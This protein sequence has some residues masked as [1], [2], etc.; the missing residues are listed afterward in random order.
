MQ[1]I[2]GLLGQTLME[3]RGHHKDSDLKSSLWSE[4]SSLGSRDVY[5]IQRSTGQQLRRACLRRLR[6]QRLCYLRLAEGGT[7]AGVWKL[8]EDMHLIY[9]LSERNAR[10][11]ERLYRKKYPHKDAPDHQINLHHK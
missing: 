9:G 8:A 6:R 2:P 5:L 10:A 3:G 7:A 11:A 1:G 4:T